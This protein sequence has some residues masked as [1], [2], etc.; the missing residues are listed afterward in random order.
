M[1]NGTTADTVNDHMTIIGFGSGPWVGLR[2][3]VTTLQ[4]WSKFS[5]VQKTVHPVGE[6]QALEWLWGL[7]FWASSLDRWRGKHSCEVLSVGS[8]CPRTRLLS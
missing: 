2:Q 5:T 1:M 3:R 7:G 4:L 8:S 6:I